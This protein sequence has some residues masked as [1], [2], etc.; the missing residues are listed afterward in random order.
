MPDSFGDPFDAFGDPLLT[1]FLSPLPNDLVCAL[2]RF[3][4]IFCARVLRLEVGKSATAE[5]E[6]IVAGV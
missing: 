4:L 3:C 5:S 6:T 1:L 2:D